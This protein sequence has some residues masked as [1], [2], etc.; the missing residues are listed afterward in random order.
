VDA[1]PWLG[2]GGLGSGSGCQG[3]CGAAASPRRFRNRFDA[4]PALVM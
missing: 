1:A 2:A 3:V 4:D